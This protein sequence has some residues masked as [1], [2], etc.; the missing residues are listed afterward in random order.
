MPSFGAI[1]AIR[2]AGLRIPED[3]SLVSFDDHFYSSFL[4]TPLTAVAQQKEEIGQAGL[5][6]PTHLNLR[7]SV[8]EIA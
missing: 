7:D 6:L 1:R 2:E 5:S 3:V 8:R 4:A